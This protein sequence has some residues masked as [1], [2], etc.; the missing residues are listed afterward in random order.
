MAP[1]HDRP[2]V[3]PPRLVPALP[4]RRPVVRRRRDRRPHGRHVFVGHR[5]LLALRSP[6]R[7]QL[8]LRILAD[9]SLPS[10]AHASVG[11]RRTDEVNLGILI[12]IQ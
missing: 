9:G 5:R 10:A 1:V 2:S 8:R 3:L 7:A 11:W 12:L 6:R 4:H